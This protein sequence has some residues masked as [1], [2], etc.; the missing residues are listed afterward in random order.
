[1]SGILGSSFVLV[2]RCPVL[3]GV[4]YVQ[5]QSKPGSHDES[6]PSNRSLCC[7]ADIPYSPFPLSGRWQAVHHFRVAVRCKTDT[8]FQ[9]GRSP[10]SS[11]YQS[12]DQRRRFPHFRSGGRSCWRS[13]YC[14][15]PSM[16][17]IVF[18]SGVSSP[19]FS[20]IM[21]THTEFLINVDRQ[22]AGA[23]R[24][25]SPGRPCLQIVSFHPF[26]QSFT[27][28]G[29]IVRIQTFRS[30]QEFNAEAPR[31]RDA[32]VRTEASNSLCLCAN[33]LFKNGELLGGRHESFDIRHSDGTQARL[34]TGHFHGM[35]H[36][37]QFSRLDTTTRRRIER[38]GAAEY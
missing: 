5:V 10:S 37:S 4:E 33:F 25:S 35:E 14:K 22:S 3:R 11:Y 32:K 26:R 38:F 16:P 24:W 36:H 8:T 9:E 30:G 20:R 34:Q 18:C 23:S 21:I 19:G 28:P 29:A 15:S 12:K 17:Q 27:V 6:L 13:W 7:S 1:M 31:R 2:T